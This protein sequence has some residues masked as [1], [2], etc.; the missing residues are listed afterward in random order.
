VGEARDL[1]AQAEASRPAWARPPLLE[2]GFDELE[3]LPDDALDHYLAAVERGERQPAVLRR[4]RQ[5]LSEQGRPDPPSQILK[6][7]GP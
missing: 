4:V 2:A 7:T 1:L 3:G 5:L 6:G